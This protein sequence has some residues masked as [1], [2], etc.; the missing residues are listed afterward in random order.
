M[1]SLQAYRQE[2][3]IL[4]AS[5]FLSIILTVSGIY[6][7]HQ[8]QTEYNMA[9]SKLSKAKENYYDLI[10]KEKIL[11]DNRK[12]FSILK[13]NG[14][15]G[16]D[17]RSGWIRHIDTIAR[18]S[19]IVK[20]KYQISER[21]KINDPL[22][23]TY[24]PEIEIYRSD[25]VLDMDLRHEG[26]FLVFMDRLE[27]LY[28]D[29]FDVYQCRLKSLYTDIKKVIDSRKNRNI[30][31]RC[32]AGWIH[33][34]KPLKEWKHVQNNMDIHFICPCSTSGRIPG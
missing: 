30:N 25:M 28:P 17:N 3:F 20:V 14:L 34:Q 33:I 10:D 6:L 23:K 4:T 8:K 1:F 26:D 29:T 18:N 21:K 13:N 16:E 7:M 12:D 5:V 19:G 11:K 2:L 27:S 9:E 32:E 24:Y 15:I 31:V 22:L